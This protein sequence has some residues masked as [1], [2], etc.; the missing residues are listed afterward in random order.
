MYEMPR[1]AQIPNAVGNVK[2]ADGSEAAPIRWRE[3]M[4]RGQTINGLQIADR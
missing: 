3:R 1:R 4:P 2:I